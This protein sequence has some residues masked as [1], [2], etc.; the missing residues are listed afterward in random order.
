M[1]KV[2][3]NFIATTKERLYS[4]PKKAGQ[5]IFIIDDRTIFLD[6]SDNERTIY[7]AIISVIN[8]ETRRK[9]P[10]PIEGFYYVRQSNSLWS[11]YD[12]MWKELIGGSSNIIF[13]SELPVIGE[14]DKLYILGDKI[15][16]WSNDTL[17]YYSIAGGG[18]IDWEGI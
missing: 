16:G 1:A 5:C 15:Y 17:S 10:T 6:I 7:N 12:G 13:V 4:I 9:I 11:Y 3:M 8:D 2:K 18:N 14:D